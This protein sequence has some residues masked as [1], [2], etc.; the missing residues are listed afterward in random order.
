MLKKEFPNAWVYKPNDRFTSGI[1]DIIICNKGDFIA[2]ELK[3]EIGKL[4]KLQAYILNNIQMADGY[5][6]V[7]RTVNEVKRF[8]ERIDKGLEFSS[9]EKGVVIQLI[10]KELCC[11]NKEIKKIKKR[12]KK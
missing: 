12:R 9:V 4:T 5:V 7:C 8:V 2:I 3:T 1:P 10:D 11:I 6:N